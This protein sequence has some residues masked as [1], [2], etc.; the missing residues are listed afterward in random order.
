MLSV[1]FSEL[2]KLFKKLLIQKG[3]I[4]AAYLELFQVTVATV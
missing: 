1:K 4:E 3:S 2:L